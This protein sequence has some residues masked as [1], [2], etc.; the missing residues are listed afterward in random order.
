MRETNQVGRPREFQED[1]A[2]LKIMETFWRYGYEGTSLSALVDATQLKKGSL[3]AAFGDKHDMYRKALAHYEKEI[4]N[5]AA[6]FLSSG[7]AQSYTRIR[8]FLSAPIQ[9]AWSD[10]DTR[11]CFL[12][13]ASADHADTDPET[14]QLVQRGFD[15]LETSM[16][17]ALVNLDFDTSE[18]RQLARMLLTIYA[19]LRIMARS[20]RPKATLENARD[21]ALAIVKDVR[22]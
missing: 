1:A 13:N 2:L 3:Y 16:K 20:G 8:D 12:C 21:Y 6:E 9:A 5:P 10:N 11:G 4:V 17:T 15:K 18:A 19:G 14:A 7:G 22:Q